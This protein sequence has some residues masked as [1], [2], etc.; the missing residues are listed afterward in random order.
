MGISAS[1]Q[2]SALHLNGKGKMITMEGAN[3]LAS[4]AKKNFQTLGL[5]NIEVAVGRFQDILYKVLSENGPIDYAFIDGHLDGVATLDYFGQIISS[6]KNK[7]VLIIDNISWSQGMK[8]A[9][10]IIE[11]DERVKISLYLRQ[12][13]ICILDSERVEKQS[14]SI[15]L[16]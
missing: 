2:A 4:I 5:N 16:Y 14:F 1:F 11:A 7:A 9:W 6:C 15:P 10:K 8:N 13:G 12:L 3:S